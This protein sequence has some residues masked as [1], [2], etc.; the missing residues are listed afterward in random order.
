MIGIVAVITLLTATVAI[1]QSSQNFDLACRSI[2]AAGGR[3]S[4]GG[5]FAVIG[6]LGGPIVPP[7]DSD[8]APTYAVR[9]ANF[10]VRAGFL[11]A[12]PNGQ[13]AAVAG[14]DYQTTPAHS[15]QTVIQRL[16]LLYK[17]LYIIRGGC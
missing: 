13:S 1:A 10:G 7:K 11:P 15:E 5:N 17:A 8:T 2:I 16:P 14:A 3:V 4:T 6:A 12:Y 9:S